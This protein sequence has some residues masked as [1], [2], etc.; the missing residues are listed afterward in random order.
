[1]Q[2]WDH[3]NQDEIIIIVHKALTSTVEKDNIGIDNRKKH[4]KRIIEALF[5][6]IRK[7]SKF[8]GQEIKMTNIISTNTRH[9]ALGNK[10]WK[11]KIWMSIIFLKFNENVITF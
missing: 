8:D 6:L 11:G 7:L 3:K 2:F 1:M 5:K 9:K 10:L 4:H